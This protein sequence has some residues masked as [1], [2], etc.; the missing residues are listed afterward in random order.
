[1]KRTFVA[2][3]LMLAVAGLGTALADTVSG[4]VIDTACYTAEKH[5]PEEP[6]CTKMCL[7]N[8]LPGSLLTEDGEVLLLLPKADSGEEIGEQIKE[9]ATKEVEVEGQVANR[10]GMQVIFVDS[11]KATN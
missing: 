8:G 11:I 9:L 2:V 4:T 7:N 10:G 6:G 1:M 3:V 5:G